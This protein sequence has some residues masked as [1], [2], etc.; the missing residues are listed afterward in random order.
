MKKNKAGLGFR[1][2]EGCEVEIPEKECVSCCVPRREDMLLGAG[3]L[4]EKAAEPLNIG[5]GQAD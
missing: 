2:C 5:W 4:A 3:L 1:G